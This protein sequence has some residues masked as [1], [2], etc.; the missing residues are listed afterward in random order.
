MRWRVFQAHCTLTLPCEVARNV[1][2]KCFA[3]ARIS[4]VILDFVGGDGLRAQVARKSCPVP[5]INT[6]RQHEW[7]AAVRDALEGA[8]AQ[9]ALWQHRLSRHKCASCEWLIDLF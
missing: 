7:Q 1:E 2:A 4:D 5:R 8:C 3:T 6:S 9:L